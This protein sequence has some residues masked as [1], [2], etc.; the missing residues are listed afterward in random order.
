MRF[1]ICVDLY[2]RCWFNSIYCKLCFC[3]EI[4]I[5]TIEKKNSNTKELFP[6][7]ILG[8]T[9]IKKARLTQYVRQ[10]WHKKPEFSENGRRGWSLFYLGLA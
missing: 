4:C 2:Y 1:V 7:K 10:G 8:E 3:S 9:C 6:H 5:I